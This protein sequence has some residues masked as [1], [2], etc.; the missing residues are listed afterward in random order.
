VGGEIVLALAGDAAVSV[1]LDAEAPSLQAV[2]AIVRSA[3]LGIANFELGGAP[4]AW[5]GPSGDD[6]PPRWPLAT[7]EAAV[8]LRT[9]G[10]GA[11]SLAN[12][13]AFDGGA[14]GLALLQAQLDA[15]SVAHAG[16]GP[17]LD[18]AR[19]AAYIA[20]PGGTVALVAMTLSHAPGARATARRGD[21]NGRPGVNGVRVARRL[22]VDDATFATLSAAF[23]PSVL[24]PH[25]TGGT[26]DLHGVTI[27]RGER[28]GMALV[29]DPDD[30][31]TLVAA[32]RAA[33]GQAAAVVVS[34]HAHEPGNRI[35]A[36]PEVLRRLAHA[37]IDAGAMVVHGHGPHRLRGVEVYRG[38]PIFYSLGNFVFPD[39]DLRPE[40]ADEFE[41]HAR[42]VLSPLG[43]DGPRQFDFSGD[44]WWQSALAVV[45]IDRG[46]VS[47]IELH[48]LDVG[49]GQDA[50]TR[51]RPALASPALG[52]DILARLRVLSA[53]LG[54]SVANENGIG[55]VSRAT[56]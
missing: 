38:R 25:P 20:T 3:S 56:P 55:V 23:P 5:S 45:R 2:A 32:V 18:A 33:S 27:E 40:A 30:V 49:V 42:D 14:D 13:H 54:T 6:A 8:Q 15:A 53:P 24:K 9:L 11:V 10:F 41:N 47:R 43:A 7:A 48:P 19:Q 37:A 22:T 29:A 36:V 31:D 21:I 35:D 1:P 16:A 39:R 28:G 44:A 26:W 34:L 52:A 51:G 4:P 17:N 12:N 50:A 46:R